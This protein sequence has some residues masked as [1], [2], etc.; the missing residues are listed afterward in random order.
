MTRWSR[1]QIAAFVVAPSV[2]LSGVVGYRLVEGYTWLEASYMTAITLSTVGYREV[3]PLSPAGQ[4]FTMTLL[5]G[6]LGV[7]LYTAMAVAEKM[8]AGELQEFFGIGRRGMEKKVES[9]DQHYV[10][11]GFGRIGEAICRELAS[12]PVPFVGDRAGRGRGPQGGA[13]RLPGRARRRHG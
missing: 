5:A 7:V 1:V 12:K 13:A 2:A 11:C 9:L 8:V 6:G 4:I 3:R 10:V